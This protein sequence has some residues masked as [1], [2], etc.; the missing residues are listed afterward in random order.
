MITVFMQ[1]II[2]GICCQSRRIL[3][4]PIFVVL[5]IL[6][7]GT[8]WAQLS[9]KVTD[10]RQR[11]LEFNRT[12]LSAREEVSK[13]QGDISKAR[14]GALPHINV[15][16]RYSRNLRLAPFFMER[17]GEM[18]E[19][20]IGFKNDFSASISLRQPLWEGGKV[21]TAYSIAKQYKKYAEAKADEI[22]RVVAYNAEILFHTVILEKARLAVLK[23]A[24]ETYSHNL[25]VV[26]K[27]HSQGL[28]S[29]FELLRARVEESNV[30]PQILAAESGV[31]LA[32]KRLKSFLGIDLNEPILLVEAVDDTSLINLPSLEQLVDSALSGRSE[33]KQ[34]KLM[35][36]MRYKAVKVARS[37]YFPSLA[38]VSSYGWQSQSDEFALDRN[39]SDSWTAG[40]TLS[41]PVFD[42][43]LTSGEV[44]RARAEHRQ[45]ELAVEQLKDDITLE[46]EQAFDRLL[47]ARKTLDIQGET[48]AQ[49]EEGM[50]IANLRYEA[51]EGTL[52]EVLS[53][54]TALTRART[55]LAQA[56]FAFRE[57]RANLRKA[58]TIDIGTDKIL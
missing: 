7:S 21:Y 25:D 56:T 11:A 33:M 13:A 8:V 50:R 42:G 3:V 5:L 48:I 6:M 23:Q 53:A 30:K 43:G 28:V 54:Q 38:A 26:E 32:E 19:I 14:S 17:D 9:L 35:T 27:F 39:T 1:F 31:R 46:V 51:G 45:T 34:A 58:T 47:Q 18:H 57:A 2:T 44:S 22:A 41:I 20:K 29:R 37:G 4:I 10:V 52:L 12:C 40:V 49:A 36:D 24:L 55:S 15:S 16:T